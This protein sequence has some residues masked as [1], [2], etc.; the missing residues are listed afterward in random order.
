MHALA[1]SAE[2]WDKAASRDLTLESVIAQGWGMDA[3]KA[4]LA[5]FKPG[6][7]A[8]Q[9]AATRLSGALVKPRVSVGASLG[10]SLPLAG[11]RP[12][13]E[14]GDAPR[15]LGLHLRS[16]GVDVLAVGQPDRVG[17]SA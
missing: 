11:M 14:R 12:S 7:A 3:A 8:M 13:L 17:T 6:S 10:A 9:A 1:A 16:D 5:G 15:A 2:A 4:A